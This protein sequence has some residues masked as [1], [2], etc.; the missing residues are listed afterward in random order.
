MILGTDFSVPPSHSRWIL[1]F[2]DADIFTLFTQYLIHYFTTIFHF[3]ITTVKPV[4]SGHSK[5][6]PKLFFKTDYC[7]M[8]VKSIAECSKWSILQYFRPSLRYHFPLRPLFCLFLSGGLRQVLLYSGFQEGPT[9]PTFLICSYFP[10]LFH[11]NALLSLLF[12]CKMSLM[13]KNLL[14]RNYKH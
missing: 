2:P 14:A 12:H 6:R 10:L 13:H 5:R 3:S 4:L 7:L 1:I 11:E 8:Q 9:F